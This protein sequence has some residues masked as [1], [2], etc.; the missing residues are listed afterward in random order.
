MKTPGP[1]TNLATS[2]LG[3]RQNEQVVVTSSVTAIGSSSGWSTLS[4]K[5]LQRQEIPDKEDLA[6]CPPS[7]SG[8]MQLGVALTGRCVVP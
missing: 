2:S 7:T 3:L 6:D 1:A 4:G 8:R 5:T